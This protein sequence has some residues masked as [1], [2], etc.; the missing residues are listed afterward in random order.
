MTLS[1]VGTGPAKIAW[2]RVVDS[3]NNDY[4]GGSLYEKIA[5]RDPGISFTSQ[6]ISGT[7]MRNG[8]D[9][10][11]FKWPKPVGSSAALAE[12]EKLNKSRFHLSASACYCSIFEEC[13]ITEFG[14]SHPKS[15]SSCVANPAP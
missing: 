5:K 10:S 1:N 8:G 3:E 13:R 4:R 7:L 9:R 14:D 15:V 12:W 2:F 11:V 6:Q